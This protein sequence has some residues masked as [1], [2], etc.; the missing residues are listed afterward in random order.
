MDGLRVGMIS[1]RFA[2]TDGVSL[3]AAKWERVL[4]R[5]GAQC[6]FFAGES[7]WPAERSCVVPE[8]H[9]LHPEIQSLQEELFNRRRRMPGVSER[10]NRLADHLKGRLHDFVRHFN[11]QVLVV[12]NALSLPMNVPLGLAITGLVSETGLPTIAHHHDFSW[13]RERYSVDAASDYLRAAFPPTLEQVQHVVINSYAQHQLA[14]QAGV[15]ST[16]IPNVMDFDGPPP[17]P[18]DYSRDLRAGL[19]IRPEQTLILQPTRII[20]RKRIEKSIELARRL[21]GDPVLLV[22]HAAGDEGQDYQAY[23]QD[24]AALLD[25]HMLVADDRCKAERGENSN[26]QKIFSLFDAYLAADLV[27]YPSQIEGF[28]NALLET[29]YCRRP[30]VTSTYRILKTDIQPKGFRLVEFDDYFR[31]A[32]VEQVRGLLREPERVEEMV[33]HNYEVGRRF[34]SY[35]V[36][37]IQ[38]RAVLQQSLGNGH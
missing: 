13:E 21:G 35:S 16:V 18:D 8:A 7:E 10:V 15:S 37:E 23:L 9:F 5:L 3:E 31:P 24:Y 25:V 17:E 26:G 2:G 14:L 36:L 28:G 32:F 34:Y 19:G 1:T 27:A 4:R 33:D 6:F 20:P 30:V 12:E 11:L 38:L 22:T 29:I